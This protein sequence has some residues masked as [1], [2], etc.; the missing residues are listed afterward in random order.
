MT[1]T[2]LDA[3]QRPAAT[4]WA[5]EATGLDKSFGG[6]PALRGAHLAVA[7]GRIHALLGGNGS[8]KSTLIKCVA[9]VYTADAGVVSVHGTAM[10]AADIT[11]RTAREAGLRFVHQDLGM[12]PT[13]TVAENL[14]L[15]DGFPTT[16]WQGIRWRELHDRAEAL[17]E[18]FDIRAQP[19]DA[20]GGLRPSQQTMVA[21]AR[22][23]ADQDGRDAGGHILI[24]DEPT[25]SLPENESA[26]LMRALRARADAGQTIVLVS[27]RFREIE[28]V[29]DDVT[30]F[31]DGRVAGTGPI[32]EM[33][34]DRVVDL[35]TGST[36]GPTGTPAAPTR[37]DPTAT[38]SRDESVTP[39]ES[40]FTARGLLAG[41]LAGL[42]LSVS[43]GEIVGLA[44]LAGSGRS[45]VLR[46]VF[47]DLPLQ[48]GSMHLMGRPH[49]PAGP[50]DAVSAGVAFVPE[51]R[52]RDAAFLD[53]SV[54]ENATMTRIGRY[55][56]RLVMDLKAERA[57]TRS[58][59]ERHA[60]RTAGTE[61]PMASLSGG[62]QQKV[63]LGRWLQQ[64]PDLL[65]LDE[66]TQGVDVM[67]RREIYATLHEIAAQGCAMVVASSD[68]DELMEL[69][70]RIVVL[71]DGRAT[72]EFPARGLRREE[73]VA[74][75]LT[76]TPAAQETKGTEKT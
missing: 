28:A 48:A 41:S 1:S 12:F 70:D 19:T 2:P 27:H 49:R 6:T 16:A 21:I 64:D 73:L 46:A 5:L 4:R 14:A 47:G 52:V 71:T 34:S 40:V 20:V 62:N 33:S 44:G 60:I 35:M 3:P 29:A 37:L 10:P 32:G 56:R 43:R 75:V 66:P 45:S 59:I 65:L 50:G 18:R 58:L 53:M 30:V 42:D 69:C 76:G 31:R 68:L 17:L 61:P 7:P 67:S 54:R 39:A 26:E 38:A 13:L 55:W 15:S 25:A 74:A 22:A 51:N 11:P 8:G 72:A 24:L 63:I 36:A 57:E 23:L 9:G